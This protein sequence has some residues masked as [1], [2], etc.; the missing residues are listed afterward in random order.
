MK[1][2]LYDVLI[3]QDDRSMTLPNEG[4]TCKVRKTS[5]PSPPSSSSSS[6]SFSSR[7]SLSVWPFSFPISGTMVPLILIFF[8][9]SL[10]SFYKSFKHSLVFQDLTDSISLFDAIKL[11][12]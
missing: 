6:F 9:K 3:P 11:V 5:S 4:K 2:S 12:Q 8:H 1:K 7:T 10:I